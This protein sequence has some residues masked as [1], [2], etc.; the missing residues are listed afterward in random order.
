MLFQIV[1]MRRG[2]FN[3]SIVCLF[4]LITCL[5]DAIILRS[6]ILQNK[7]YVYL[8]FKTHYFLTRK[9]VVTFAFEYQSIIIFVGYIMQLICI[10]DDCARVSKPYCLKP[11]GYTLIHNIVFIIMIKKEI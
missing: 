1:C 3:T 6:F 2:V 7:V 11:R 9:A 5:K 8:L 10:I 4:W